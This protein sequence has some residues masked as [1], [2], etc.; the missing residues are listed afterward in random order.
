MTMDMTI[1]R[2]TISSDA[3]V[4]KF[5]EKGN[6]LLS[7]GNNGNGSYLWV[8]TSGGPHRSICQWIK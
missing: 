6:I 2:Y 8:K 4:S 3:D 1:D 5:L 7:M